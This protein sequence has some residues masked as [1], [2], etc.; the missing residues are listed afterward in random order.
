VT[1]LLAI[2]LLVVVAPLAFAA[3]GGSDAPSKDEYIAQAGEICQKGD[4]DLAA[5][6]TEEFGDRMPSQQESVSFSEEVVIPN[7]EE[8]LVALRDLTP[9]DGDEEALNEIYG[10]LEA[11]I[12]QYKEDIDPGNPPEAFLEF[13]RLIEEY[14]LEACAGN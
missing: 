14:G 2:L 8:Q 6:I 13:D 3:C 5:A 7:I 1:K 12:N 10:T 11:A 9:P 4:D